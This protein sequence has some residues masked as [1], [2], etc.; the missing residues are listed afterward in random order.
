MFNLKPGLAGLLGLM[1]LPM[2]SAQTAPQS[3]SLSSASVTRDGKLLTLCAADKSPNKPLGENQSPELSWK[4][5][6]GAGSYAVVMFDTD[7]SWLHWLVTGITSTALSLGSYTD[8]ASYVGPYPPAMAGRHHYHIIVFAL[9]AKPDKIAARIDR[10][11]V[12]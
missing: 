1:I 11:S 8:P 2:G 10:K 7:A 3:I 4:P 9:K 12:V 6:A 5:V